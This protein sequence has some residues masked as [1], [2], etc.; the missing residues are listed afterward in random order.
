MG[1]PY[2]GELPESFILG[3][4]LKDDFTFIVDHSYFGTDAAYQD[5]Q[6]LLL[7]WEGRDA[8]DDSP[9]TEKFS[10]GKGWATEDLGRTMVNPKSMKINNNSIYGRILKWAVENEKPLVAL[11][12]ERGGDARSSAIWNGLK[13]QMKV[14]SMNYGKEIGVRERLMPAEF[15]G[16]EGEAPK[17]AAPS[18]ASSQPTSSPVTTSTNGAVSMA[19][20][21]LAR[22]ASTS[23]SFE[24]FVEGALELPE[25]MSDNA[26]RARIS[27]ESESGFFAT[28]R[29]S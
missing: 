23:D 19:E 21:I 12:I 8:E 28:H 14:E 11:M 13:F 17:A 3:T 26:L 18:V 24:T 4:G 5:G 9:H 7:I 29:G 16:V 20:K 25:V 2:T 6:Q 22:L 27:D 10:V 15:L 1:E